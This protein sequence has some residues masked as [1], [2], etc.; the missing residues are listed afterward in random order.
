[1]KTHVLYDYDL[2]QLT[3]CFIS[4]PLFL[5]PGVPEENRIYPTSGRGVVVGSGCVVA[6]ALVSACLMVPHHKAQP[7]EPPK[8]PS[9]N[10]FDTFSF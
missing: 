10:Y 7:T 4:F 9:Y 5:G 6:C 1:M 3:I 2:Y 8:Y